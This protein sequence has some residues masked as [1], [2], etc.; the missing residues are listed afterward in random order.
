MIR[1]ECVTS[2]QNIAD[3]IGDTS[4][5]WIGIQTPDG[6]SGLIPDVNIGGGYTQQQ[7]DGLGLGRCQ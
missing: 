7:L 4:E 3:A 2:G 6:S 1:I 5:I